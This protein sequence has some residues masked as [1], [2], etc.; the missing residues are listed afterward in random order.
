MHNHDKIA[1]VTI[2][3]CLAK[4]SFKKSSWANPAFKGVALFRSNTDFLTSNHH[5]NQS[6]LNPT[7]HSE[8]LPNFKNANALNCAFNQTRVSEI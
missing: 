6:K 7:L 8:G 2:S 1:R 4:N 5:L 3:E